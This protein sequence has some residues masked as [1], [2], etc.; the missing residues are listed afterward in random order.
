MKNVYAD[1]NNSILIGK[2]KGLPLLEEEHSTYKEYISNNNIECAMFTHLYVI[3]YVLMIL[4][5]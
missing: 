3:I 5:Y 2:H 4:L 1:E